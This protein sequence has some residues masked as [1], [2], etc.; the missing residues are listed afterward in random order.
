MWTRTAPL[1]GRRTPGTGS[2]RVCL[3][4]LFLAG[5]GR[6]ASRARFVAPHLSFGCFAPFGNGLPVLGIFVCSSFSPLSSRA[7]AVS[8]VLCFRALGTLD[9]GALRLFLPPPFFFF[10]L[11]S[12]LF[13]CFAFFALL[14]SAALL[15]L[16]LVFSCFQPRVPLALSFR[17]LPPPLL[18]FPSPP[19]PRPVCLAVLAH[20]SAR[21]CALCCVCPWV[22]CCASMGFSPLCGAALRC[23][24]LVRPRRAVRL[25]CAVSGPRCSDAFCVLRC[26]LWCSAVWCFAALLGA[27]C[28]V[29]LRAL[30]CSAASCRVVLG[31]LL[32]AAVLCYAGAPVSGP[33]VVPSSAVLL[34]PA[35]LRLSP[36]PPPLMCALCLVLFGVAVL[37]CPSVWCFAVPCCRVLCCVS[38]CGVQPCFVVGCSA[39]CGALCA[40]LWVAAACC[41]SSLVVW[42]GCLVRVVVC[43]VVLLC[44]AVCCGVLCPPGAVLRRVAPSCVVLLCAVLFCFA[45]LVP[46]LVVGY[47]SPWGL[48]F[49]ALCFVVLTT[50]Y[51]LCCVCVDVVWWCVLLLAAVPCAVVF[52]ACLAVRSPIS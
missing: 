47:L 25:V 2:A 39:L 45:R 7:P 38:G 20:A 5:S 41:A 43:C 1:S 17:G 36:L 34:P 3:C 19:R 29:L 16:A 35:C 26:F 8:R 31:R 18:F 44:V 28:A 10:P 23:G 22:S 15:L 33:C 37:C 48:R 51:A 49:G 40:A 21:C 11:F 32:C 42:S 6:P 52:L 50:L 46:L 9:L 12:F 24:R 30:P 14:Y 27:W 4:V 13:F